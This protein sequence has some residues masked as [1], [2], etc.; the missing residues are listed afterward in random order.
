MK[1]FLLKA[2]VLFCFP[3]FLFAQ[4]KNPTETLNGTYYL[5]ES[6]RG[7]GNKQTKTKVA[8]YA[9]WGEDYVMA[10]AAC[11]KCMPAIY[12]YKKEYSDELKT[13]VFYNDYALFL[14]MYDEE[15]FIIMKPSNKEGAEFTDFSFSN[16]YSKDKAKVAAMS[17]QKIKEYIIKISE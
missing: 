12:K 17:Q 1:T 15:S 8:Q 14:I 7:I 2:F 6:E 13:A 10:V 5:L 3:V 16:F 9:K 4:H 11:E